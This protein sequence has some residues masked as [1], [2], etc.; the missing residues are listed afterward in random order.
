MINGCI[1]RQNSG[2][3][4]KAIDVLDDFG[5]VFH[6]IFIDR[7]EVSFCKRRFLKLI[8]KLAEILLLV[9]KTMTAAT[10][11]KVLGVKIGVNRGEWEKLRHKRLKGGL[12]KAELSIAR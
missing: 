9:Q 8:E 5:T 4:E 10:F 7:K 12:W 3:R 6:Q 2:K 11:Q 1:V